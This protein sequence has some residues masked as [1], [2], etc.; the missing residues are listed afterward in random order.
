VLGSRLYGDS[1]LA[2]LDA[3]VRTECTNRGIVR[4]RE[5]QAA[6]AEARKRDAALLAENDEEVLPG[7]VYRELL[8]ASTKLATPEDV[9]ARTELMHEH[10]AAPLAR[11]DPA[12]RAAALNAELVKRP[13]L[14]AAIAARGAGYCV[15]IVRHLAALWPAKR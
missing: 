15:P 8:A 4:E 9:A 12:G 14:N 6:Q 2:V 10:L 13:A 1:R 5:I 3:H 11:R 7:A